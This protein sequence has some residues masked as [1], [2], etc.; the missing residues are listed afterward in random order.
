MRLDYTL[1]NL[2]CRLCRFGLG[3]LLLAAC[4]V[5][6]R[7]AQAQGV[8]LD[9]V[10]PAASAEDGF[11]LGR[12]QTPGAGRFNMALYLDY[13]HDPLVYETTVGGSTTRQA[14]VVQSLLNVE[15]TAALGIGARALVFAGLETTAYM[16][17]EDDPLGPSA[18][19]TRLGDPWLGARYRLLG[20]DD[21]P[22]SIALQAAVTLPLARAA[23]SQ[24]NF[25][26]E[27]SVSVLPALLAELAIGRLKLIAN[28][29]ARLRAQRASFD[30]AGVG[31]ELTYGLGALLPIGSG[32]VTA[33]AELFGS[34]DAKRFFKRFNSPLLSLLGVKWRFTDPWLA[35]VSGG[36]GLSPGYGSPTFQILALLAYSP[37]KP[38]PQPA[39]PEP[40]SDRDHDGLLDEFDR[41][42]DAPEDRDAFEDEDGCPDPDND[43]DGVLDGADQC[44][45][46]AEDRDGFEDEDG[47]PDPDNDQDG[48]L[49]SADKCTD[50]AEDRDGFEDEDGCPDPDN[51]RDGVLDVDDECPTAPGKPADKGCPKSVRVENGQILILQ[52]VEFATGRSEVLAA[53]API[54]DE[55]RTTIEANPQLRKLRVEGHTDA[56]GNDARNMELSRQR[57]RSVARW[58]I[59]HGTAQGR[60]E[61]YGCGEN[62]PRD[63]NAT[64]SG[65]QSNRRVEVHII[66]PAPAGETHSNEGC[67]AIEVTES[68]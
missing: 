14:A 60:L 11:T 20:D 26:G 45:N 1:K 55:V 67:Q 35:G 34:T 29:G 32:K 65:R 56:R 19:G 68:R 64:A 51:D 40:P 50:D 52:R 2:N 54:L 7:S 3:V 47:C 66:D 63:S 4:C 25:A 21:A 36:P 62:R 43:Q 38:E 46:D 16:H 31:Q 23:D 18:D 27:R 61:A 59:E 58:L 13:A 44:P 17:G 5:G 33:H 30:E 28:F 57:A 22:L 9:Q 39:A 12:P 49:D 6:S 8:R 37:A 15:L 48:I 24:Q 10:R 42:P 41:C 53:S